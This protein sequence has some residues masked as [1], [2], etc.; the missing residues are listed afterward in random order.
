V[1]TVSSQEL[2]VWQASLRLYTRLLGTRV[3]TKRDINRVKALVLAGLPF[4][5]IVL[6]RC[7]VEGHIK[8]RVVYGAGLV[9]AIVSYINNAS[10]AERATQAFKEFT[11]YEFTVFIVDDNPN[12]NDYLFEAFKGL[13]R[14]G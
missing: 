7:V 5:P 3:A 13:N 4:P 2:Y 11:S 6:A 9:S 12:E 10:K 1:I 14:K 8:Y